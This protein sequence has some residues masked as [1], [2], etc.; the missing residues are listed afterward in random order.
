MVAR[1]EREIS[2]VIPA[3]KAD[4]T[5]CSSVMKYAREEKVVN[6]PAKPVIQKSLALSV[7][8]VLKPTYPARA[9]PRMLT[10]NTT[11]T[12]LEMSSPINHREVEPNAPPRNTRNGFLRRLLS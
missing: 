5:I 2:K 10:I 6:P 1:R 12:P 9:V 7:R 4:S 8:D 3:R 11:S